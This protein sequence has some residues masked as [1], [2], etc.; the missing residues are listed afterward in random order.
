MNAQRALIPP[1]W[2]LALDATLA[3]VNFVAP[4]VGHIAWFAVLVASVAA[5]VDPRAKV[6]TAFELRLAGML[7]SVPAG[8]LAGRVVGHWFLEGV[9]VPELCY[10]RMRWL[11][12]DGARWL[13]EQ[14]AISDAASARESSTSSASGTQGK[15]Y[16]LN[17]AIRN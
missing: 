9:V 16:G 3:A 13:A 8:V 11:D 7:L 10:W 6:V 15:H 1:F 14:K 4:L 5:P 2:L 17:M 12:E